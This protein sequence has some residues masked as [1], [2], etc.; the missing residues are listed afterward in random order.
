MPPKKK[1]KWCFHKSSVCEEVSKCLFLYFQLL[2]NF[3]NL[4]FEESFQVIQP[5]KTY[6]RKREFTSCSS[7]LDPTMY[8]NI[9]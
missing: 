8:N 7:S 2:F 6:R 1:V 9:L 3:V 4:L 5:Q